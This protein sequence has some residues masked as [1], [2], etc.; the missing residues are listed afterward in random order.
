MCFKW[1]KK[2]STSAEQILA[3][4]DEASILKRKQDI[5][6]HRSNASGKFRC[7]ELWIN[8]RQG[9]LEQIQVILKKIIHALR[10][11][12]FPFEAKIALIILV[13]IFLELIVEQ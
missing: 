10:E 4:H 1:K 8:K 2:K 11:L 5:A 13:D 7:Y 9:S 6:L 3:T 12:L